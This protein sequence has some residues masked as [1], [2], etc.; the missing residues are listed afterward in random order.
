[1]FPQSFGRRLRASGDASALYTLPISLQG[2]D[3]PVH[4]P[5]SYRA[6]P[7]RRP[8]CG[9]R[10]PHSIKTGDVALFGLSTSLPCGNRA[11]SLFFSGS[12]R[13][14]N[15]GY[16]MRSIGQRRQ[17]PQVGRLSR[18]TLCAAPSP[19]RSA[20]RDA[21]AASRPAGRSPRARA[22]LCQATPGHAASGRRATS[23]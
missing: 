13:P 3:F 23:R 7:T 17:S 11:T 22:L 6:E 12:F 16:Q 5:A 1:V 21:Q 15:C 20:R 18:P 14:Q 8:A 2:G 10:S 19:G 9:Q 4:W